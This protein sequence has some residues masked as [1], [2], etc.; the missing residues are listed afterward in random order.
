MNGLHD[1]GGMQ[2]YGPVVIEQDEPI[3]HA[4]WERRAFALTVAM[5]TCGKWNIDAARHA[6]ESLPPAIYLGGGYYRIWFEAL[7]ALM[8]RHG[9]VTEEELRDGQPRT[10][11][12]ADARVL[13]AEQVEPLFR[14]G[15]P[16]SRE[17][18][19]PARFKVGDAVRTI[20][21]HP[22]GHTRLPRY[23]RDKRGTVVAVHGVHVLPDTNALLQGEHPTWLYGIRF[24]AG[25]LWGS[26]TTASAV[27]VDCWE[28]YLLEA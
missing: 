25:E 1:M 28:T 5:G 26:N 3:F 18:T 9:L 11:R 27:H 21:E 22:L 14:K 10:P 12:V 20:N 6:R 7:Q 4:P 15:W 8:L 2:C 24:E 23:C 16:S 13:K 19:A 17:A